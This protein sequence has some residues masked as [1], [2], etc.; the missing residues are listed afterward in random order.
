MT[1]CQGFT[2]SISI[3]MFSVSMETLIKNKVDTQ[4]CLFDLYPVKWWDPEKTHLLLN[5]NNCSHNSMTSKCSSFLGF[6]MTIFMFSCFSLCGNPDKNRVDT[7]ILTSL[8]FSCHTGIFTSGIF[9][10][11]FDNFICETDL[12]DT[13]NFKGKKFEKFAAN[14]AISCIFRLNEFTT[15]ANRIPSVLAKFQN[16]LNFPWQGY[17]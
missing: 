9:Y 10:S 8:C 6:S 14:I 12:A 5:F 1:S 7:S 11:I 3:F 13:F 15:W 4:I 16:F 17:F 2:F